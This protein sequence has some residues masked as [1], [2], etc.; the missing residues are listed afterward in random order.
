MLKPCL[1]ILIEIQFT[2]NKMFPFKMCN[3]MSFDKCIDH[4]PYIPQS[5]YRTLP[6]PPKLVLGLLQSVPE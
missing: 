1:S 3:L 5:K 2:Y 6:S 4:V